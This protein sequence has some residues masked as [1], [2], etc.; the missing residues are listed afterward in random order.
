MTTKELLR[1][2]NSEFGE[3]MDEAKP[4][5][6]RISAAIRASAFAE[7]MQDNERMMNA[8][9]AADH[10]FDLLVLRSKEKP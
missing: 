4:L 8:A 10:L 1:R 5:R 6:L 9:T 2:Y 3:I 7:V